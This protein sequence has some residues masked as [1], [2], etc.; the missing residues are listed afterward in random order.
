MDWRTDGDG[1]TD[2]RTN[3]RTD[4][5]T[6]G[7]AD[8]RDW[9]SVWVRARVCVSLWSYGLVR[10]SVSVREW[11]SVSLRASEWAGE[12]VSEWISELALSWPQLS[13]FGVDLSQL[14]WVKDRAGESVIGLVFLRV[15]TALKFEGK[16]GWKINSSACLLVAG[17]SDLRE[18]LW[19][20]FA[21]ICLGSRM[22]DARSPVLAGFQFRSETWDRWPSSSA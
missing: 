8:G 21:F 17:C 16:K 15:P 6:G 19:K 1:L 13:C 3:S 14:D 7:R 22:Q 4:G 9:W 11:V 2:W 18:L 20:W 5:R 10:V 12:R